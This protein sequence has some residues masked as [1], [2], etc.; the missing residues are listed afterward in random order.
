MRDKRIQTVISFAM[1]ALLLTGIVTMSGCKKKTEPAAPIEIKE[2]AAAAVTE[3][4]TCPVMGG[5]INT[6]IFTEYKGKKVYF[7]CAECKGKF[8]AE[9]EKY[10][11][12]L[13]Q[14]QK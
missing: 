9:P 1:A 7:C 4:T 11:S 14:L 12:K 6:N 8:E 5:A 13:P 2:D 3:Q 10:I